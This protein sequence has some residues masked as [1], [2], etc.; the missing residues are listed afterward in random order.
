MNELMLRRR[1][2]MS[3][4]K[5]DKPIMN[6]SFE[7][8][9]GY[10]LDH[11]LPAPYLTDTSN[12]VDVSKLAVSDFIYVGPRGT[13][14]IFKPLSNNVN[15]NSSMGN[16]I[17]YPR[18]DTSALYNEWWNTYNKPDG[19]EASFTITNY[20][21]YFRISFDPDTLADMYGYNS[22]TGEVYY[23][24][25]NTPYYGKTNIND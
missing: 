5:K 11:N 14:K 2:M 10:I 1:A 8:T 16:I 6:P 24:G 4:E 15:A 20:R 12:T 23:A 3:K 21:I 22:Q 7:F 19:S 25:I 13:L 17:A 9:R 18:A